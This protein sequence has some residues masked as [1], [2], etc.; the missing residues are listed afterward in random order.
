LL[1]GL[2]GRGRIRS[3]VL[4]V[5][6]DFLHLDPPLPFYRTAGLRAGRFLKSAGISTHWDHN[7]RACS[8]LLSWGALE[9]SRAVRARVAGRWWCSRVSPTLISLRRQPSTEER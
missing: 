2:T 1:E 7:A 9:I 5:D 3:G 4:P 8:L 6:S